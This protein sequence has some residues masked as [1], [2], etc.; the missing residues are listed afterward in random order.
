MENK[1]L[2]EKTIEE[3]KLYKKYKL[4]ILKKISTVRK[5]LDEVQEILL[6]ENMKDAEK[7]K[8]KF[9][10]S[11]F[12]QE[13]NG[14]IISL[15]KYDLTLKEIGL[16]KNVL[17]GKISIFERSEGLKQI[18][19][20]REQ[21]DKE[22]EFI[23]YRDEIQKIKNA[24]Q[25][26]KLEGCRE[27][28]EEYERKLN[29]TQIDYKYAAENYKDKNESKN[30]NENENKNENKEKTNLS[31]KENKNIENSSGYSFKQ[32][33]NIFLETQHQVLKDYSG[34]VLG[35]RVIYYKE[36]LEKG[37]KEIET[38]G[39]I[40]NED[41]NYAIKEVSIGV[42]EELTYQRKEMNSYSKLTGQKSQIVYQKYNNGN[43]L[44]FSI[45]DGRTTMRIEKN[46]RGIT[47]ESY[48]VDGELTDVFEYDK[49]GNALIPMGNIDKLNENYIQNCFD[50]QVPYFEA[51]NKSIRKE[52]AEKQVLESAIYATQT[53]TKTSDINNQAQ[54]IRY[55]C[56][57]RNQNYN[58][59][60]EQ[61][62]I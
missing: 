26:Y 44:Y 52:N 51:E 33:G 53:S 20:E 17:E 50:V 22:N 25:M 7:A 60:K 5:K 2:F 34:N 9:K 58:H 47:I 28:A 55:F 12:L 45:R 36:E 8:Y 59:E 40:E 29:S 15:K 57:S 30:E 43:E 39:N 61:N 1:E 16:L 14:L 11:E 62:E 54:T 48:N 42:G 49:E 31:T 37:S 38:I 46:N 19:Q 4:D 41:G 35:N 56:N 23:Y 6:N 18:K 32:E 27:K 21:L 24:I 3:E 13:F 10:E